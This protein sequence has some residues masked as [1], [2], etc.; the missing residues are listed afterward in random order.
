MPLRVTVTSHSDPQGRAVVAAAPLVGVDGLAECRVS[1]IFHLDTPAPLDRSDVDRLCREVLV[2]PVVAE[3]S[4]GDA[5][6]AVGRAV[7][8]AALPGVTDV[9]ARELERAA[10]Q[11]QIAGL[12]VSTAVR[13]DLIGDLDDAAVAVTR[14]SS[15]PGRGRWTPRSPLERTRTARLS[16][17]RSHTSATANWRR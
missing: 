15:S 1:R 10:Q 2:D 13:Y 9:E 5:P 7:E 8:V 14:R 12:R 16:R 6:A 17:C 4:V 3:Y 11:L